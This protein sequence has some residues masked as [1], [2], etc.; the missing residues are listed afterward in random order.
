[1]GHL[2]NAEGIK[3]VPSYVQKLLDWPIPA[4]GKELSAFL[5]FAGYYMGIFT[6]VCPRDRK[7][8]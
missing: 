2:I 8:E 4:T 6:W 1:M 3:L 5:G 7:P